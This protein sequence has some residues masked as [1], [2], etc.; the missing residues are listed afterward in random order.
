MKFNINRIFLFLLLFCG[1]L[2]SQALSKELRISLTKPVSSNLTEHRKFVNDTVRILAVM[3]EFQQDNDE[4]TTGNGKFDTTYAPDQ[5]DPTPH[6]FQY[7]EN[8]LTFVKN[9]FK[10]VS[11]NKLTLTSTLLNTIISLP[12]LMSDYSNSNTKLARL[13]TDS[14][15]RADSL[16]PELNFADYDLFVIFHAGVGQDIDMVGILGYNPTPFDISSLYIDSVFLAQNGYENGVPVDS[17]RVLI[18]NSIVLPET[19]SRYIE[20]GTGRIH[21]QYSINGLFAACIGN[22]L[23]L[24]DL[25]DTRT[26]RSGIGSFGLMDGAAIFGYNGLF[27]PEPS[28]W[29][30]IY[31]GWAEPIVIENSVDSISLPAVSLWDIGQD[32]I[33]K[34]PIS[35]NEYFLLENRNRNPNGN[36][37]EIEVV[38]ANG[39]TVIERF[40]QDIDEFN[41]YNA[42]KINASVLN[43]SNFDWAI[44]DQSGRLGTCEGGGILIWHIDEETINRGLSTNTVNANPE[45][46]GVDLEEADGSQDIGE[47]YDMLSAGSGSEYGNPLDFWY[48]ENSSVLYRNYFSNNSIPNSRSY[49]GASSLITIKNFSEKSPRMHCSIEIGNEQSLYRDASLYHKLGRAVNFPTTTGEHIYFSTEEGIF[50]F[51]SSGKSLSKYANGFISSLK[52]SNELAAYQRNNI[53]LL[54]AAKDNIMCVFKL[55]RETGDID[56]LGLSLWRNFTTNP[57]FW[58]SSTIMI[59][60]TGGLYTF[61]V[62]NAISVIDSVGE[63]TVYSVTILLNNYFFVTEGKVNSKNS[64]VDLPLRGNNFIS[65]SAVS[66]SGNFVCV[67]E[68]FGN[69]I[70]AYDETLRNKLFDI[71]LPASCIKEIAVSDLDGDRVKDI[72][73]Q[74][75]N[76]VY[77]LNMLGAILEGFPIGSKQGTSFTGV[78]LIADYNNDGRL[79][80]CLFANNGAVCLYDNK[81]KIWP[82]YPVQVC[83]SGNMFPALYVSSTNNLGIAILSEK[84]SLKA[85]KNSYVIDKSSY[86]WKQKYGNEMLTNSDRSQTSFSLRISEF[87]PESKVYNWPN[88]V[89]GNETHIRYYTSE[90]ADVNI[91]IFDLVGVKIAELKGRG[92]K[93]MENEVI[94]NVSNIQSGIYLARVE[95]RNSTK[96]D[97]VFIKIAIVK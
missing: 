66:P 37:V 89:Y 77:A 88:P 22:F 81:G 55:N 45:H 84:D 83:T 48:K 71:T 69:R 70:I 13:V 32:T 19:E 57:C 35:T 86:K 51:E 97:A 91:K 74:C 28:A 17:G 65:V 18:K 94:W 72:I 9:Y 59:G 79:E 64:Q 68:K 49:S 82:G 78:P 85:L 5:I 23:G 90:D 76:S 2:T 50:G 30:K 62:D 54:V 20:T 67:A 38:K 11:N 27:P 7:F 73:V 93:G 43:V 87:L 63:D 80:L 42:E 53:D 92:Y 16:Y 26:G 31:L 44:G 46:R 41:Y 36:G 3:I 25:F 4:R 61:N 1:F 56:S 24:P 95:A 96:S 47:S 33:Y 60:T 75:E 52:I 14:W 34:I 8:K 15:S 21:L 10:K 58:D 40:N 6:N 12:G 29:E 39:D